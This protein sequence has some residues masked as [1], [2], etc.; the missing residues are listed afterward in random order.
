MLTRNAADAGSRG[1]LE[2]PNALAVDAGR[3]PY[4]HL[5]LQLLGLTW[6]SRVV[7]DHSPAIVGDP[8]DGA[9]ESSASYSLS[10]LR[11]G[12]ARSRRTPGSR[13]FDSGAGEFSVGPRPPRGEIWLHR[14]V[15]GI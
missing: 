14:E 6:I 7:S 4:T 1:G 10:T 9:V 11:H 5:F 13:G 12:E 8:I 2:R 15:N 3:G